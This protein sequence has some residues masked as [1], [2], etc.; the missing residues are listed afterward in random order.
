MPLILE[1]IEKRPRRRFLSLYSLKVMLTAFCAPKAKMIPLSPLLKPY[2]PAIWQQLFSNTVCKAQKTR[3]LAS[4]CV[5]IL[6]LADLDGFMP[7]FYES[8]C[9]P[10][11]SARTTV[12][13]AIK[14]MAFFQV[15]DFNINV[16]IIRNN[17]LKF[18]PE[19]IDQVLFHCTDR[20]LN[21]LLDFDL[22]VRREA[23]WAV[24]RI[25]QNKSCYLRLLLE[26]ILPRLYEELKIK[27]CMLTDNVI[28]NFI[29]C[30]RP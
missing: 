24:N 23:W 9:L 18:Q 28:H 15:N 1:E 20:F 6:V 27:V 19:M 8:M 2:I 22:I 29:Q 30:R 14:Y 13:N 10:S 5:A 12:M 11:P 7:H 25:A 21:S 26:I 4:E 16:L 17:V 3:Q